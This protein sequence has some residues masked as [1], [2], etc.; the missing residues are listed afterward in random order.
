VVSSNRA[1]SLTEK[2][3]E[4]CATRQTGHVLASFTGID[5]ASVYNEYDFPAREYGIQ[6]RWPSPDPAG[7]AAANPSDPQSWNRYAYVRN[8]PLNFT[9]PTGLILSAD[10][11]P[12]GGGGGCDPSDPTCGGGCDPIFG[13]GPSGGG[14]GGGGYS[15]PPPP[16]WPAEPAGGY[17]GGPDYG[18]GNGPF[19]GA[20]GCESLGMP[21]GMRF[22]SR[23]GGLSGCTYGSGSCG[24][25]IYGYASGQSGGWFQN[26]VQTY[27][28]V[29]AW[30]TFPVQSWLMSR[31]PKKQHGPISPSAPKPPLNPADPPGPGWNWDN[32]DGGKW[33]N[34][35]TGEELHPDL[36][37]QPPIGPHWDY[38]D[39]AGQHWRIFPYIMVL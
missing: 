19:S 16:S 29:M 3:E 20:L 31:R 27:F 6:G 33:V 14:G 22:P 24:G 4:R 39:P 2:N 30:E 34:P 12:G 35:G 36:N 15:P 13:C 28:G 10:P 18:D 37:H 1:H 5:Q 26:F 8:S 21:C 38:T 25:M 7:L 11:G 9:D 17:P 32:S 23:G